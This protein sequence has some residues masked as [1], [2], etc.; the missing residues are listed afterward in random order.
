MGESVGFLYDTVCSLAY[1]PEVDPHPTESY[2]VF[3]NNITSSAGSFSEIAATD[4]L[5]LDPIST[6]ELP[7]PLGTLPSASVPAPISADHGRASELAWFRAGCRFKSPMLQLHKGKK[8]ECLFV[9]VLLVRFG[10][11]ML[12][13]IG[14]TPCYTIYCQRK[15]QGGKK[16]HIFQCFFVCL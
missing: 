11:S 1:S 15:L 14:V 3:R 8:F 2:S 6:V 16:N 10:L 5:S 12:I 13:A 9:V 7:A 4:Y